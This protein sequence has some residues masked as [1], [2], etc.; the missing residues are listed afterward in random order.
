MRITS[1]F[2]QSGF[3]IVTSAANHFSSSINQLDRSLNRC[4][5]LLRT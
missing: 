4:G 5:I 2:A 3:D 1:G